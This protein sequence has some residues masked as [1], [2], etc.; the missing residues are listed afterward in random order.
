MKWENWRELKAEARSELM[1]QEY[2]VE[3]LNNC[4]SELQQQTHA[5]RL[6]L[7]NAHFGYEESRREPFRLQ[8]ELA[9]KENALRDTEIRSI[10]EMR[11]L[12]RAQG[13]KVMIRYS[14]SLH[15]YKSEL[16]EWFKRISKCRIDFQWKNYLTFPVNRHLFQVFVGC[17]AATKVC[18]LMRGTCLVHR[19]PFLA[20][21]EQ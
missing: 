17:W 9:M 5:Q 8:E 15:R 7:D 6:E 16:H 18:D 13:E 20:I 1:K 21:H 4:M 14:R 2:K 3:S 12:R 10:H 19:E 11:E